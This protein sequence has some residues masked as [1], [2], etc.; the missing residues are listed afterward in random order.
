[1]IDK[2][3]FSD[4]VPKEYYNTVKDILEN[5]DFIKLRFFTQPNT[6]LQIGLFI[7]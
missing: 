5:K 1:M 3:K 4:T 6:T 7:V 2:I